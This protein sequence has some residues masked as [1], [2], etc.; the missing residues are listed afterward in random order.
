MAENELQLVGGE[1]G[2]RG[3]QHSAKQGGAE[4]AIEE[5]RTV[6]KMHV[7]GLAFGHAQRGEGTGDAFGT[8]VHLRVRTLGYVA[9]P[10]LEDK[11]GTVRDRFGA[12]AQDRTNR[13]G[14]GDAQGH[15]PSPFQIL[16]GG[17]TV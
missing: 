6:P 17:A 8:P 11:E 1:Q 2:V 5:L 12:P 13:F 14:S 10:V 3:N 16:A 4:P 9:G 7:N 15:G